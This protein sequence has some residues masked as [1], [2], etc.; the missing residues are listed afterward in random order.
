MDL[1]QSPDLGIMCDKHQ[2]MS[3]NTH[4]Y[5]KMMKFL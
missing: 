4:T 1:A 5:I 3:N 2:E